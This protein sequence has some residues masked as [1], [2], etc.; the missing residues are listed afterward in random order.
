M[1]EATAEN[2]CVRRR[3]AP[4][5]AS[6]R[7]RLQGIWFKAERKGKHLRCLMHVRVGATF[8]CVSVAQQPTAGADVSKE[9]TYKNSQSRP[10]SGAEESLS[11]ASLQTDVLIVR[12]F[13]WENRRN[14]GLWFTICPKCLCKGYALGGRSH[15]MLHDCNLHLRFHFALW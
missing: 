10:V 6:H 15:S 9:R 5:R 1:V 3:A 8:G 13:R 12:S 7:P 11:R 4:G 2:D 14:V